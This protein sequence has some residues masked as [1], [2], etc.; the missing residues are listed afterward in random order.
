[1]TDH[2]GF[3]TTPL[4]DARE[5]LRRS[6]WVA[7]SPGL[8]EVVDQWLTDV[9]A[10]R[11]AADARG[12]ALARPCLRWSSVSALVRTLARFL[13]ILS[14]A[15]RDRVRDRLI[16]RRTAS[17]PAPR[18]TAVRRAESL[19]R[20]GGPAYVKL[21]QFLASARGVL[22][23]EVVEAF[24]WCRDE[25]PPLAPGT[26][27]LLIEEALGQSPAA[28]FATF[29]TEPL[30]AASIAQV[31]LATLHDGT[32]V[33]VK[34]RRP[35]LEQRF[36]ADIQAMSLLSWLAERSS[37]AARMANASGTIDLFARL[38]MAELDF[39]VEAL[40]M[41]ELGLASE[42][43]GHDFVRYPR[44]I[45]GMVTAGVL[46]MEHMPG[47]RYTE[48]MTAY[49]GAVDGRRL[50]RVAITG[51][52]E[53]ALVYG[54][55]HGDLHAGNVLVDESGDFALVD[56][57]IA[58][59]VRSEERAALM[60][61]TLGF[62]RSDVRMQLAA[63]KAYGA[64]PADA[65]LEPLVPELE[66][67][68]ARLE[69]LADVE[70]SELSF[71]ELG[72]EAGAII[73][74]LLGRGFTVPTGLVLFAKNLLYLNGL[75]DAVAPGVNVLAEIEPVLGYFMQKYPQDMAAVVGS[76]AGPPG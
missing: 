2:A 46:V 69:A 17:G 61:L 72:A 24:E 19:V 40:N 23:D 45:P 51:V 4:P 43:A 26:A 7:A 5:L 64:I 6:T 29:D 71:D 16:R 20:A 48:A 63:M 22:A 49:P 54:V 3:E 76:L 38:C 35:G 36:A 56:F 30:A 67:R 12:E 52:L 57:G 65:D 39:R 27:E 8:S 55:F 1:M 13:V 25:V 59:R 75:A 32:E 9:P 14:G 60:Q 10:L 34:V 28:L 73:R 50:L 31:H 68:A 18:R 53:Q 66:A 41:V 62:A 47:V 42:D 37:K 15:A 58:G 74:L 44:P 21:G 11:D 33:V 70:R